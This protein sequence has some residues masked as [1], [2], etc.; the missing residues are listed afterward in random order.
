VKKEKQ[1]TAP[2]GADA[3][4]DP[5][6]NWK[7]L[8]WKALW[9]PVRRLQVRIAKATKNGNHRRASA[10]QW[11]PTHSR[12]AKLLAVQRVTTNRG[13]KTPGVDRLHSILRDALPQQV[14]LAPDH[15]KR[16]DAPRSKLHSNFRAL[17]ARCRRVPTPRRTGWRGLSRMK[18][19]F[20]VRFLEGGGLA[21]ACLYSV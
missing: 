9:Q 14:A 15:G 17:V 12:A 19:N 6:R 10:L 11:L 3:S 13:A 4:F 1:M 2:P 16:T 5:P 21:T 18:G 8:H 20:H 7:A